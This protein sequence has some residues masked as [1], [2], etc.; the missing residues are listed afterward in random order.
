MA[1]GPTCTCTTGHGGPTEVA[2]PCT[3]L[4]VGMLQMQNQRTGALLW[5]CPREHRQNSEK[6]RK[7]KLE[8]LAHNEKGLIGHANLIHR[9]HIT[10]RESK[11]NVWVLLEM[12][13]VEASS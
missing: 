10:V 8:R 13:A 12:T 5:A 2:T 4:I 1:A 11:K 7:C 3:F 6:T 9:N